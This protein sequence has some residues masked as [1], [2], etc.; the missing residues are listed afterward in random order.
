MLRK[1]AP[2]IDRRIFANNMAHPFDNIIGFPRPKTFGRWPSGN[3][4]ANI[5]RAL[6][7]CSRVFAQPNNKHAKN[8]QKT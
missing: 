7:Q 5:R 6:S 3:Q 8:C 2:D 4:T 1:C